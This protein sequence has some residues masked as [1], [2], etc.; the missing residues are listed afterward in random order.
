MGVMP[1][2]KLLITM[3]LPMMVSMLIQALYNIVDSVFVSRIPDIGEAALTAVSLAF[4]VQNLMI[5]L[6][7]GTGVGINA[8]LSRSL[9]EKNFDVVNRTAECGVFLAVMNLLVVAILGLLGSH[10]FYAVQ[11]DNPV[12]LEQGTAYLSIVTVASGGLF[13]SI[14][15]ERLL[16]ST[17]KTMYTMLA[18]GAG[19]LTNI[20]LDPIFIFGVGPIPAMG[21]AGAAIATVIGQ[22]LGAAVGIF[23]HFRRNHEIKMSFKGFRPDRHIIGRI[24]S[25]GVPSIVMNSIGSVAVFGMNKIL[26][27]FT[28]TAATV[29]GVYF[30]IQSFIFMPVFGLNNGLVPIIAYNYGAAR[31]K[32]LMDTVKLGAIYATAIM[33]VGLFVFQVFTPQLLGL[34]DPSPEMLSIGVPA[35]RRI[36]LCFIGAGF[37]IVCS[38]TFQA[39]GHGMLSM[40]GSALRQLLAL[41]PAAWLLSLTGE[42][43]M[44]WLAFPISECFSVIFYVICLRHTYVHA[45]KPLGE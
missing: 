18:Q 9:G 38:S 13:L 32:R 33:L 37:G 12:I 43:N 1:V 15:F 35:L 23:L 11:T 7:V 34:F 6:A 40:F 39:L 22:F 31:R 21:A 10:A 8:V 19:A 5:A 29:F 36:S 30:K 26:L 45:I 27:S 3:S 16:Q 2:N 28:E 25:V 17:G 20:I 4:P 42:L 44:V 41:L 14:T 24:Y